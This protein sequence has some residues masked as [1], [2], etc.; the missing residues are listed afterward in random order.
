MR[1]WLFSIARHRVLVLDA[2]K[3][4]RRTQGH[5]AEAELADAPDPRPSPA[6]SI[7]DLRLRAA[8]AA[9][10]GELGEHVRTAVLLGYQQGFTFEE[11]AEVC[12]EKSD[13]LHARVTRALPLL[14]AGI[15]SRMGGLSPP[16]SAG[17]SSTGTT[18]TTGAQG[19]TRW[20]GSG[21]SPAPTDARMGHTARPTFV[22]GGR[23]RL[24]SVLEHRMP[25][26]AGAVE[27]KLAALG[28]CG[29]PGLPRR[30]SGGWPVGGSVVPGDPGGGGA[31]P[32]RWRQRGSP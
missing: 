29:A 32:G 4:R 31:H 18:G 23:P 6:E 26:A 28:A 15:E 21:S 14:R 7:D 8:L 9:G 20:R 5:I 27:G 13:T 2:A 19:P 10:L 12:C 25:E 30:A 16:V 22:D 11:M 24:G 3:A 17:T 1:T